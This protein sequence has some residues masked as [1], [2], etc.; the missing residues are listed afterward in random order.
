MIN[1]DKV[2]YSIGRCIS[3]VPDACR[4]CAYDEGRLYN[5]CVDMMLRDALVLLKEQETEL[6]FRAAKVITHTATKLDNATCPSCGNVVGEKIRTGTIGQS[7]VQVQWN[8][9]CFCGQKLDW[10]YRRSK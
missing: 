4:D 3:H 8:Y 7:V 10:E 1:K 2:I 6:S 9:C 5:E